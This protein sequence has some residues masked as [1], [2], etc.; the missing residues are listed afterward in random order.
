MTAYGFFF[1]VVCA[2]SIYAQPGSNW[3]TDF[4]ASGGTRTPRYAETI[5][6]C[7][8]LAIASPWVHYTSFGTSP[9]GRDLPLVILS[10]DRAFDPASAARTGKAIILVQ[11]CI[12][13]GEPDGKDASLM[14]MRDIAVTKTR[15]RLLDHAILL[16]VPIFNVDGHE[17]FGP[18]NRINQNG[19]EEAG[20]RVNAQNL[21]LNRDF[22]KA[23]TPEMRAML[24]LF[25]AWLPDLFVDC[26]VTDG[27]DFQYDVTYGV[28]YAANV[29]R[30]LAGWLTQTLI[31][32]MLP[33]VEASGHKIF[34]YVSAREDNDLSKGLVGDAAS[35]RF[36]TGYAAVQNRP[37]LFIETHM[38]KPYKMR[39][40]ATY[41]VLEGIIQTVNGSYAELKRVA[42]AADE[43]TIEAG[44]SYNPAKALPLKLKVGDNYVM[45]D[46]LGIRSKTEPSAISGGMKTVYTGE[47]IKTTIP[48]YEEM[49]VTDSVSI[50]L[51]YLIPD[52]WTS[53]TDVIH[54]HGIRMDTL[55]RDVSVEVESYRFTDASWRSRP[56]EGRHPASYKVETLRE[57]RTYHAGS[58]VV[59]MDQRAAKVAMHLLEPAGPDALVSWG[60][61][62]AIFEQKEYAE[63]YVMERVGAEMLERSPSLRKEFND[64]IRSD[65]AFAASPNA[66]LSWLYRRSAWGDPLLN[67]YPVG[68][69]IDEQALALCHRSTQKAEARGKK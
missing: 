22:M 53:V 15:S 32:G 51:A 40:E 2:T 63:E 5:A 34:Y 49:V 31:P 6:Y 64:K 67:M 7:K 57:R 33:H 36:S 37:S 26:H 12:H 54:A 1:L 11:S 50:P 30:V 24:R 10:R 55:A 44:K 56:Y 59:P 68:R 52:E 13:A 42:K 48:Y 38:L 29:E 18:Y 47:P 17:R 65:S 45:K 58:L 9:Q 8:R 21:N 41:A 19:P 28:E 39:V 69:V 61:F 16:F 66:R 14:L 43:Q 35:P 23:D 62:D 20:W 60:F 25:S 3:I 4:E 27:M 46:F